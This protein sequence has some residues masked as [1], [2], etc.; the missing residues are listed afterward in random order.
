[1]ER[2]SHYHMELIRYPK[3]LAPLHI[4]ANLGGRQC[5]DILKYTDVSE[6]L[7]IVK[8]IQRIKVSI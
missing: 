8:W 4:V 5:A 7:E 2:Q 3:N 6:P 1:M